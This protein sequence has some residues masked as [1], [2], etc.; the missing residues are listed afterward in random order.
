MIIYPIINHDLSFPIFV[1]VIASLNLGVLVTS[2]M[3][4]QRKK[5]ELLL[6]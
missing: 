1:I 3:S 6:L 5:K 4:N 2:F